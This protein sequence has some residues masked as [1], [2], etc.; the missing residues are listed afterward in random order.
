[1]SEGAAVTHVVTEEEPRRPRD[2]VFCL[3]FLL[4]G[5]AIIG[6]P[7]GLPMK[8]AWDARD[9][10][11][12]EAEIVFSGVGTTPREG[13]ADAIVVYAYRAD[14]REYL[15]TSYD[16]F[17]VRS[18]TEGSARAWVE[19]YPVGRRLP[20]YVNP[21][22]PRQVVLARG[23]RPPLDWVNAFF[24]ALGSTFILIGGGGLMTVLRTR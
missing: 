9:W 10:R 23:L 17:R 18:F 16:F 20:C 19:R 3:A 13:N 2:I 14:G 4:G 5:L 22:A 15:A 11:E 7:W 24:A 21:A 6:G 8:A 12:A 1:L